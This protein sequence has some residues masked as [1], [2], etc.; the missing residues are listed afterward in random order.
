ML[1]TIGKPLARRGAQA[2]FR[3]IPTYNP[4]VIEFQKISMNKK[5]K[6]I[7]FTYNLPIAT[8]HGHTT[9]YECI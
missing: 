8:T 3:G 1:C 2:W 9:V 4:K 6:K 7:I 5:N